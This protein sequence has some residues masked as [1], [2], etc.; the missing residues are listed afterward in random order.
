MLKNK[1]GF[2]IVEVMIV[3]AVSGAF[4][5]SALALISGS[6]NKTLFNQAINDAQQQIDM[7]ANNVANGY[8]EQA[9]SV[10]KCYDSGTFLRFDNTDTSE[11][12]TNGKCTFLGRVM[13]FTDGDTATTY[14]VAGLRQKGSVVPSD[15]TNMADAIPTTLDKTQEIKWKSGITVGKVEA[16]NS[17]V[18]NPGAI[19]FFTGFGSNGSGTEL[20]SGSL[21]ADF[22][23]IRGSSLS[24]IPAVPELLRSDTSGGFRRDYELDKN[25]TGGIKICFNSG[26]TR[27]HGT[28]TL[29]GEGKTSTS[30]LIIEEGSC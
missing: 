28:I 13:Q 24:A 3:L 7:M 17:T 9:G 30:T 14:S 6:Q 8:Y 12:G 18:W 16:Y 1:H 23:G 22:L 11:R 25:T 21:Q 4:L 2:T 19:G 20:Q 5:V 10:G 26:T 29:G 27:Q 15:V